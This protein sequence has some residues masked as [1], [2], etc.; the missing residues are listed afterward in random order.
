MIG[1]LTTILALVSIAALIAFALNVQW[2]MCGMVNFGLA[3]FVALGAYVTAL[4]ALQGWGTV[5]A[6]AA[7]VVG[8]MGSPAGAVVGALGMGIVGELATLVVDPNYRA[9]VAFL[10][11]ALVLLIR[12]HGLFGRREIKK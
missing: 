12:P 1:Y 6:V 2:G 7:A 11:I 8:G 5:P 9:G 3:G 4:I 10:A